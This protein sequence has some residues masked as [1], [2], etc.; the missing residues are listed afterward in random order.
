MG[1][2]VEAL[3]SSLG[4]HLMSV[5]LSANC[6][7][8][9]AMEAILGFI[10]GAPRLAHLDLSSNKLSD[11]SAARRGLQRPLTVTFVYSVK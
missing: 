9:K 8:C 10:R 1:V 2:E 4:V 7:D 5:D 11:A 6:F 3:V